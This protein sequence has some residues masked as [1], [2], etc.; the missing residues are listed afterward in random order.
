MAGAG[1]CRTFTVAKG[2]EAEQLCLAYLRYIELHG[3]TLTGPRSRCSI[4]AVPGHGTETRIFTFWSRRAAAGF[5]VFWRR[6]RPIY[7]APHEPPAPQAPGPRS[8]K[9]RA[10]RS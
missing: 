8:D 2:A 4:A 10:L 6:Y 7:G 5:E 9:V 3:R 1:R